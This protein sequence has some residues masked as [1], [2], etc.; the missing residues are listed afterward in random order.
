VDRGAPG[1]RLVAVLAAPG[2]GPGGTVFPVRSGKSSIGA[3]RG[4]DI[5]LASDTEVSSEH[6]LILHRNGA[7]HLAD[8]LSTNGTWL[9]GEEVPANGT[10][11]L[12][13]RD[14]IRCGR[15]ELLFLIVEAGETPAAGTPNV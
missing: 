7:F 10:V 13:D 2:L 15:T 4:S 3:D 8:R 14:R 1:R 9:N 11:P 12:C 6:A 5:L